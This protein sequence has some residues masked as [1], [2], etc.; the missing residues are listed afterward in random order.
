MIPLF[1]VM[2]DFDDG[3]D[4][5]VVKLGLSRG[6]SEELVEELSYSREVWYVCSAIEE[7]PKRFP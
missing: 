5:E 2:F 6:C 3:E 1:L 7:K 4:H